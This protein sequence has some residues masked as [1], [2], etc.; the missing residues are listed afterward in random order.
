MELEP[1]IQNTS[2]YLV[3]YIRFNK[4]MN[5]CS[6]ADS[7]YFLSAFTIHKSLNSVLCSDTFFEQ[8]RRWRQ[9]CQGFRL[10]DSIITLQG[11][12]AEW[13]TLASVFTW[14]H[15]P[16]VYTLQT[17]FYDNHLF[18]QYHFYHLLLNSIRPLVNIIKNVI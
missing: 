14:L 18:L 10:P 1:S 9:T 3:H 16:I 15:C 8:I 13:S 7:R 2:I 4:N 5:C 11:K 12:L 6:L 17:G